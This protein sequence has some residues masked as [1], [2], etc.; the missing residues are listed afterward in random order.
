MSGNPDIQEI[1]TSYIIG[2]HIV[3]V[4]CSKTGLPLHVAENIQ[5]QIMPTGEMLLDLPKTKTGKL[6]KKKGKILR[7][8][9]MQ[10]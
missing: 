6:P 10:M 8:F 7:S 1:A 9:L 4:V 5:V 2:D 3:E